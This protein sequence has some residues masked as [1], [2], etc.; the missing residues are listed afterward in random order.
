MQIAN[1]KSAHKTSSTCTA[2]ENAAAASEKK[3]NLKLFI[4]FSQLCSIRR[5]VVI[6]Y[7]QVNNKLNAS[8]ADKFKASSMNSNPQ[9]NEGFCYTLLFFKKNLHTKLQLCDNYGPIQMKH[10]ANQ[11]SHDVGLETKVEFQI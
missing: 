1:D 8:L 3:L 10:S 9:A 7:E 11:T 2:R 4:N 5:M 6:K